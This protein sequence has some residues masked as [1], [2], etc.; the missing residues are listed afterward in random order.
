MSEEPETVIKV[1]DA[2]SP[3]KFVR[4]MGCRDGVVVV[5]ELHLPEGRNIERMEKSMQRTVYDI[6]RTKSVSQRGWKHN[7]FK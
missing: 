2:D 3:D 5:R 4:A 7:Q 6:K 1:G